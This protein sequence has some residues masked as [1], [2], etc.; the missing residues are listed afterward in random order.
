MKFSLPRI[1][2][3]DKLIKELENGLRNLDFTNNFQSFEVSVTFPPNEEIQITNRLKDIPKYYII[4]RQDNPGQIVDGDQPW[5]QQA[6]YLKNT[7]NNT[8]TATIIITR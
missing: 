5:S 2:S 4:G 7:S 6:L 3:L 1:T 8:I